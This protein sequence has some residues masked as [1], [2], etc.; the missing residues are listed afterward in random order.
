MNRCRKF[1]VMFNQKLK[2]K[3]LHNKTDLI[4]LCYYFSIHFDKFTF[5]WKIRK[6]EKNLCNPNDINEKIEDNF[7]IVFLNLF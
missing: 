3:I 5:K 1:L 6:V 2:Y 4:N 7:E